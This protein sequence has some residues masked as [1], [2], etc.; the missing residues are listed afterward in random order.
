MSTDT[1]D[2]QVYLKLNELR[3]G[4]NNTKEVHDFS[5]NEHHGIAQGLPM[6]TADDRFGSCLH[7]GKQDSIRIDKGSQN[8]GINLLAGKNDSFTLG[9]WFKPTVEEVKEGDTAIVL[10]VKSETKAEQQSLT[11][12]QKTLASSQES[13]PPNECSLQV[14]INGKDVIDVTSPGRIKYGE[15]NHVAIAIDRKGEQ[16]KIEVYLNELGMTLNEDVAMLGSLIL[17]NCVIELAPQL[18]QQK[19]TGQSAHLRI[20]NGLL[21]L[22]E[23]KKEIQDD[24]DEQVYGMV[25]GSFLPM[26]GGWKEIKVGRVFTAT[27]TN[28]VATKWD[29]GQSEYVAQ[30]GHYENFTEKFETLLP[31][32][33]P[34]K[35]VFVTDEACWITN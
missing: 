8:K 27:A 2:L 7:L 34:C 21:A 13:T 9:F 14:E 33:S 4:Q 15:W 10:S 17:K 28:S 23:L 16:P 19:F 3:Q 22:A 12:V 5:Q 30:R 26:D 32:D 20:Y 25:D 1:K 31:P 29:M 35:K 6:P 18:D 24:A 11:I